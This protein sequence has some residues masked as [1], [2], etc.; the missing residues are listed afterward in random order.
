VAKG[1]REFSVQAIGIVALYALVNSQTMWLK[2]S[3][4][5]TP[6]TY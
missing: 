6:Q 1:E 3:P 5:R 2:F 4:S